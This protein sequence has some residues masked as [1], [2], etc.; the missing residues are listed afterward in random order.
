MI[1]IKAHR[2]IAFLRGIALVAFVSLTYPAYADT[3]SPSDA[4]TPVS[5]HSLF[6]PV[7]SDQLRSMA[8]DRPNVTNTPQTVDAGH[9]QVEEGFFDYAR[10]RTNAIAP[11]R[12][13]VF[14]HTNF[15]LGVLD[16]LEL[17]A[18]I[19]S[20]DVIWNTVDASGR[21]ARQSGVGDTTIGG[22][23]NFW[24]DDGS[25]DDWAT[26]LAIQPQIKLPTAQSGLGN[27]HTE[28]AVNLPFAINLPDD[29]HLGLQTSLAQQRN[30]ANTGYTTGWQ[31]SASVDRVLL[32]L[33][34][35]YLEYA[36]RVTAERHVSSQQTLDVGFTCPV[37]S[38]IVLDGGVNFGLNAASPV[39]E[40][41]AGASIRF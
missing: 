29:F 23:L 13:L 4:A 17:N 12:T 39:T 3:D 27:G 38:S 8:T 28:L 33:F 10:S 9:L 20:D 14:G 25:D 16:S 21:T 31:N 6:D 22:K 34:D 1:M 30:Q 18:A 24:G 19:D 35:V 41:L 36:G 37:T 32:G 11:P 40:W 26:A 15:R 5:G 2:Q 7:P